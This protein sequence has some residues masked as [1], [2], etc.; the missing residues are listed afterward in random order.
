MANDNRTFDHVGSAHIF[1]ERP[2]APPK[3]EDNSWIGPLF[4]LGVVAFLLSKCAG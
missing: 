2:P 4:L 3:K 1:R